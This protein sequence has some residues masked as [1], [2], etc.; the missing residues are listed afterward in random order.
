VFGSPASLFRVL[1]FAEAISWTLLIV[2]LV[3][4]AT[5][6][7]AIATTVGGSIH[8]FVFLSYGATAV[9]VALNNRW[10]P[11]P[12]VV[13]IV[14]AIVPYATVPA[15][16]WLARTGRLAGGW[17]TEAV[18]AAGDLWYDGLLRWFLRRPWVLAVLI[19]VAVAAIF[20][21]LLVI[22]PPGGR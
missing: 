5:A 14:S 2:G 1:A 22:G 9:L 15:E 18:D 6:G 19:A 13:A 11:W 12:T 4:R 8:G 16:L 3:L 20:T 21:A 10:R 17:R 7:L